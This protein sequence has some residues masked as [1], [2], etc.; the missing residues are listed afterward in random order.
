MLHTDDE[1]NHDIDLEDGPMGDCRVLD[2]QDDV[3]AEGT[4][5]E[6]LEWHNED[7]DLEASVYYLHDENDRVW[8][9]KHNGTLIEID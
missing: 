8:K 6:C 9:I 4:A 2:D 3:V 5:E 7:A 1:I